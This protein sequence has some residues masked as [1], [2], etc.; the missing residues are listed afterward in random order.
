MISISKSWIGNE[1]EFYAQ[2]SKEVENEDKVERWG[3]RSGNDASATIAISNG[4]MESPSALCVYIYFIYI[5]IELFVRENMNLRTMPGRVKPERAY[6]T[7]T[8]LDR[9]SYCL[10]RRLHFNSCPDFKN[11]YINGPSLTKKQMP[12]CMSRP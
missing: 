11:R 10:A 2:E 12:T 9:Y 4:L 7:K 6:K 3:M 5:N 8:A 1:D